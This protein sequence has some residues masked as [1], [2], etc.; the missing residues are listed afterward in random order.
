MLEDGTGY[1]S[2][3]VPLNEGANQVGILVHKGDDKDGWEG[4]LNLSDL[5]PSGHNEYTVFLLSSNSKLWTTAPN[6]DEIPVGTTAQQA[7]HWVTPDLMLWRVPSVDARGAPTSLTLHAS[8]SASLQIT[9]RGVTQSDISLH[10]ASVSG[11]HVPASVWAKFP[12]LKGCTAFKL[13]GDASN[14]DYLDVVKAQHAVELK[15]GSG[16]A[17]IGTCWPLGVF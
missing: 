12:F 14:V 13:Q 17:L 15:D 1:V 8:K 16:N 7:A 11:D 2:W 9:G 10:F 4:I 6:L 3:T 5:H